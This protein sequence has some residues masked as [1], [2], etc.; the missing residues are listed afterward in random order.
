VSWTRSSACSREPHS[1]HAARKSR[2]K[3]SPAPGCRGQ[4]GKDQGAPP[5]VRAARKPQSREMHSL[6]RLIVVT[7]RNEQARTA[8]RFSGHLAPARQSPRG[9]NQVSATPTHG[10]PG[11][12]AGL[13]PHVSPSPERSPSCSRWRSRRP[14]A[15]L[16]HTL[17]AVDGSRGTRSAARPRATGARSSSAPPATTGGGARFTSFGAWSTRGR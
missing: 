4:R 17:T 12:R 6:L 11:L 5:I 15:A 7:T 9:N 10:E 8:G 1:A 14:A 13:A 3:W 2:S 16:E